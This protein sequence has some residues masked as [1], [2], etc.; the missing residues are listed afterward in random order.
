MHAVRSPNRNIGTPPIQS[1]NFHTADLLNFRDTSE[2]MGNVRPSHLLHLA[3]YVEHGKF[4]SSLENFRWVEA[5]L[6]LLQTF[7]EGGGQRVTI[8]G[9]CMEYD[10]SDGICDEYLTNLQPVTPYSTCKH[11]LQMLL[12]SYGAQA[13]LSASWARIFFLYGPHEYPTRLVASVTRNLLKE[14]PAPVSN[15]E[16]VRDFLYVVDVAS[17]LVAL[18]DSSV[19]GAVNIGSGQSVQLKHIIQTIADHLGRPELVKWGAVAQRPDDPPKIVANVD[20]L[21][22]LVGWSPLY[23]LE[24]GIGETINWW[25]QHPNETDV[26][27]SD[28]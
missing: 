16:Q 8:A 24:Q 15:S 5:S 19:K 13:A 18:L 6:H 28:M 9:T 4:W 10:W 21:R 7:R 27:M 1:I 2:L 17:A 3:W 20:R 26:T 23:N 11:A 25:K 14:Q 22:N 12:G